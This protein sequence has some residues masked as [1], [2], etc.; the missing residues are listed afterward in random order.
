M[1]GEEEEEK[2]EIWFEGRNLIPVSNA[3]GRWKEDILVCKEGADIK[4][5]DDPHAGALPLTER[6]GAGEGRSILA[7]PRGLK[8]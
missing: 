7:R 5:Y 4:S 8:Q 2:G 1:E 6:E 3:S